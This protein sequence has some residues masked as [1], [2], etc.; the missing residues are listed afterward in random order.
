MRCDTPPKELL[1]RFKVALMLRLD[2]RTQVTAHLLRPH[3]ERVVELIPVRQ[4][5]L[6]GTRCTET[7]FNVQSEGC[8]ADCEHDERGKQC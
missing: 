1:A 4:T 7:Y 3:R 5:A 6:V 2:P 8:R